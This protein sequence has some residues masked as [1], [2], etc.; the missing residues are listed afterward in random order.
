MLLVIYQKNIENL[1][2]GAALRSQCL[3]EAAPFF[4]EDLFLIWGKDFYASS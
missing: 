1:R 4:Q 3:N 2:K